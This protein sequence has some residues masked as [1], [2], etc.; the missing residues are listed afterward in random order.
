MVVTLP[1]EVVDLVSRMSQLMSQR[2]AT[3]TRFPQSLLLNWTEETTGNFRPER[4]HKL[5]HNFEY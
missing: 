4:E 5:L 2:S 3:V 1:E